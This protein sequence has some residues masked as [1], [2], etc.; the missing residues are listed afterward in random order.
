MFEVFDFIAEWVRT[1]G[2]KSLVG[3]IA[4]SVLLVVAVVVGTR[5]IFS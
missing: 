4:F 3:V 2:G 5:L 1:L